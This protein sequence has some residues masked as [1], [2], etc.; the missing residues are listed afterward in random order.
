MRIKKTTFL[1]LFFVL[2]FLSFIQSAHAASSQMMV[3]DNGMDNPQIGSSVNSSSS[4]Y[5]EQMYFLLLANS[6]GFIVMLPE[7]TSML[8][9]S[10]VTDAT[11]I[12]NTLELANVSENFSTTVAMISITAIVI[13]AVNSA[14][15]HTGRNAQTEEDVVGI[16]DMIF[17]MVKE[18]PGIH[19]K[20]ICEVLERANGTIQY[21]LNVLE[22]DDRLIMSFRDGIFHRFFPNESLYKDDFVCNV[23][24]QMHHSTPSKILNLLEENSNKFVSSKYIMNEIGI[25]RQCI[26]KACKDLASKDIITSK[27]DGHT[28]KFQL[29]TEVQDVFKN[30]FDE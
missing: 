10:G 30:V 6:T 29:T 12:I 14:A 1:Y 22:K 7:I 15:V 9:S 25:S 26:S 3:N 18:Y 20:K 21:H 28:I 2:V 19:F 5:Q 11:S 4:D 27:K 16:R 24:S 17:V 8:S 13:S 23:I